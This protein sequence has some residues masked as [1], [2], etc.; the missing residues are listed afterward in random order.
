MT[1]PAHR[2]RRTDFDTE[3]S[4]F[5]GPAH[6]LTPQERW[7]VEAR[8][9]PPGDRVPE[10]EA[11]RAVVAAAAERAGADGWD[12]E[13][14]DEMLAGIEQARREAG[15]AEE[16]GWMTYG[17]PEGRALFT[18]VAPTAAAAKADVAA[19]IETPAGWRV[20]VEAVPA[21]AAR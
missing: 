20:S 19:R 15:D 10:R 21:D 7:R 6:W 9:G 2:D 4:E 5:D 3:E 17:G 12:T 11:V 1:T 16:F 14:L 13:P 8:I 18:V